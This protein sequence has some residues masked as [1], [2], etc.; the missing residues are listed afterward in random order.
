M[1]KILFTKNNTLG[2]KLIR[3]ITKESVSHCAIGFGDYVLC[4]NLKYG[5]HLDLYTDFIKENKIVYKIEKQGSP[6]QMFKLLYKYINNRRDYFIYA[7]LVMRYLFPRLIT[8]PNLW[9]ITG[10]FLS[11]EFIAQ[12]L[13]QKE[14][15]LTP[16]Q[17]YKELKK[18]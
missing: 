4:S 9:N 17:L 14:L 3:N 18:L 16:G 12:Y 5:V 2:S 8:K 1:I 7:R 11:T 10:M 15:H 13:Y 6:A